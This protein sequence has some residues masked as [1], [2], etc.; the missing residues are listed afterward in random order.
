MEDYS[1]F[2]WEAIE[3]SIQDIYDDVQKKTGATDDQMEAALKIAAEKFM[4][5]NFMKEERR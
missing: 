5:T 1:N 2:S 3:K 4:D